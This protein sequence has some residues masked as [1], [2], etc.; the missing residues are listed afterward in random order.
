MFIQIMILLLDTEM[1]PLHNIRHAPGV[2]C[3]KLCKF[4]MNNW[5]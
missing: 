3:D 5:C 2:Q 4:L 1:M